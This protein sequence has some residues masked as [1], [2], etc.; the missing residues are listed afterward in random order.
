MRGFSYPCSTI[1]RFPSVTCN[2]NY[3][4]QAANIERVIRTRRTIKP[5][6]MN[7]RVIPDETITELLA[8]ADCAPTHARTEPWRFIVIANQQ[9]KAF[10][11]RHANLW[12][13]VTD[14]EKFTQQKFNNLLALGENTSHIVMVW[15][16]R[17]PTHKIPEIEEV[18]ATAAAIENLLI[19]ATAKGIA[20]FWSTGG[21]THHERMKK[22]FNLGEE[23][24][25][26]GIIY[27]GYSDEPAKDVSRMIPL[28]EKTE[29]VR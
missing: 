3:M 5:E 8:M 20:S 29:W 25:I 1:C 7:G 16:K 27:L 11:E 28:S 21:I 22:E 10:A 14:P 19:A 13:E 15:M 6:K 12:K 4:M 17:V 18:A 2:M 9:V 24:K 26:L 23:D